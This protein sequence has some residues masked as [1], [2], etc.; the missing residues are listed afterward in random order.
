MKKSRILLLGLVIASFP[1]QLFGLT[2]IFSRGDANAD[3]YF[4][5]SDPVAILCSLFLGTSTISCEKA[6]DADDSGTLDITDAVYLLEYLF[7][8]GDVPRQPFCC[9]GID[10]TP[11]NLTCN[12]YPCHIITDLYV[13][14]GSQ[15]RIVKPLHDKSFAYID[16]EYTYNN[17]PNALQGATYLRT[18]NVDK[19]NTYSNFLF[20]ASPLSLTVYVAYDDRY[21][22]KPS[23][24]SEFHDSGINVNIGSAIHSLYRKCY[25]P[26]PPS[27]LLGEN[28][29]P[30]EGDF[31]MYTVI[32]T[33]A[34]VSFVGL[35]KKTLFPGSYLKVPVLIDPNSGLCMDDLDFVIPAGAKGGFVSLSRDAT[36]DPSNPDIMLLAGYRSGNYSLQAIEKT[37]GLVRGEAAYSISTKWDKLD[38]PSLW[39]SG[40]FELPGVMGAT[41]GGGS[42]TDPEN[43]N[44]FPALGTRNVAILLVDTSS[45]R[46]APEEITSLKTYFDNLAFNDPN[47]STARYYTEVSYGKFT[48]AGQVFGPVSLSGAWSDYLEDNGSYKGNI[49]SACAEAGDPL[50]N[51]SGFQSLVCAIKSVPAP[52]GKSV[53]AHA[54]AV[55]AKVEEGDIPLGTVDLPADGSAFGL[56]AT[57][58]HELGHNLG[59]GDIYRWDWH[60]PQIMERELWGMDLMAREGDLPQP[61]LVH[62]MMLGWVPQ[63]ALKLYNFQAI[64]GFVDETVTLHPL[65]LPNPPTGRFS[66]IEVRIAPGR[67]YYFEYRTAQPNQIG[68]QNLW[69]GETG[70]PGNDR[71][72]GTDVAFKKSIEFIN[73]RKPVMLLRVD[74][75]GDGPVLGPGQNYD[76]QD[77]SD[78]EFPT[79]FSVEV[80]NIDGTKA[81]VHVRYGVYSQPDPSIR[82]WNSDYKSPDIEVRNARSEADPK[83]QN[84]PWLQQHNT[85]IANVTNRGK[86]NAPGVFVEFYVTDYTLNSEIYG[87]AI[88]IGSDQDDVPAGQT[89]PFSTVWMPFEEGHFCITVVIAHY[90]TPGPNSV[91][92]ATELNNLA[93]SNYDYFISAKASPPS[94]EVTSVKVFNPFDEPARVR[95]R[96]AK[97]TTPLFRTYLEHTWIELQA[98]ETRSIEL[99]FEYAYEEDPIW[100]P[101]LEKYISLPNDV[102]VNAVIQRHDHEPEDDFI[103]MGGVTARI[104]TGHATRFDTFTFDPPSTALGRVIKV[105]DG[106]PVS[107]GKVIVIT[108]TDIPERYAIVQIGGN[109]LFTAE[110]SGTWINVQAYY[111]GPDGYADSWSS[112]LTSPK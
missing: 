107:G 86:M 77:R 82:P 97:S 39:V 54:D 32:V 96:V 1:S 12:G 94:R 68:D 45:Q 43:Y 111:V 38:G 73:G 36:F 76:E 4:D 21:S 47:V 34:E 67:N 9:C 71:V 102:I 42:F 105:S 98:G 18:A 15:Y 60:P 16:N 81:D 57:L 91:M 101:D 70:K 69:W 51:Y 40:D 46:F 2:E 30:G 29:V 99:M 27:I 59:M 20:I 26:G 88:W 58:A 84:V 41:W 62:R 79:D 19:F 17:V 14:S 48:I 110:V 90:Q 83:W 28:Y 49:W 64:G 72:L 3:G 23:W 33:K 85:L 103:P 106:Q 5:V 35:D 74:R 55:L 11:D 13:S 24:L 75:D 37:T 8:G 109:G 112:V 78:P 92:E 50:I 25:S 108:S 63:T 44:V 95:I 100:D 80:V 10:L 61:C 66:G 7:L 89:V 6:A 31:N 65:E 52:D 93:H 104:A 56:T 53:W 22:Q 87:Q